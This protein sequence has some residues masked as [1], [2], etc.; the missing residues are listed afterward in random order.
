E[1]VSF[2]AIVFFLVNMIYIGLIWE[3]IG[4]APL[5]EISPAL[6]RIMRVRSIATLCLFGIAAALA[7]KYPVLGLG[8]CICCLIV[9]LKPDPLTWAT[10]AREQARAQRSGSQ[11]ASS[12]STS[13]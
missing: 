8:I 10:S 1:P 3:L 7:L 5:D 4:R 6:R 12:N 9:Y 11:T 13:R 2:Y